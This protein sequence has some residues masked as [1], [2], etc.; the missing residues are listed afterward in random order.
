MIHNYPFSALDIILFRVD[1]ICFRSC[2][3]RDDNT[4]SIDLLCLLILTNS[5]PLSVNSNV[6]RFDLGV[7]L[8]R[9]IS[10]GCQGW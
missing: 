9:F 8:T 3:V 5:S 4:E 2:F 7:A 10:E 1:S 6:K